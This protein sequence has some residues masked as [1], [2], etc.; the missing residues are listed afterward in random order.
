MKLL[1]LTTSDIAHLEEALLLENILDLVLQLG[2]LSMLLLSV[3]MRHIDNKEKIVRFSSTRES[4]KSISVFTRLPCSVKSSE[5][6]L[7]TLTVAKL[8][9]IN[10]TIE[11][12]LLYWLKERISLEDS[13][14]LIQAFHL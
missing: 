3:I 14:P 13:L 6:K 11:I 12:S 1:Q 7:L 9:P 10:S 5:R 2:E 8:R 4:K